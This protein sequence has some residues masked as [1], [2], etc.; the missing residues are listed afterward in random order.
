M[1]SIPHYGMIL[2]EIFCLIGMHNGQIL[3]IKRS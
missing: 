3:E 2:M 1:L